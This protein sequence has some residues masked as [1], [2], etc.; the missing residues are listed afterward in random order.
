MLEQEREMSCHYVLK[1]YEDFAND[2]SQTEQK[3]AFNVASKK[4]I[5]YGCINFKLFNFLNKLDQYVDK[6]EEEKLLKNIQKKYS[7][8]G[9]VVLGAG[10]NGILQNLINIFVTEK[11][12]NIVTPF[13]TFMQAS[14]A[15]N[16]KQAQTR[17]AKMNKN[18]SINFENILKSVDKQTKMIFLCNPNNPTNLYENVNDIVL[19]AQKVQCPIVVSEASIAFSQDRTLLD[20]K[21][22]P[23]NIIVLRSFS[24]EFGLSGLRL[25]FAVMSDNYYQM[26]KAKTPTHV[27]S[28]ISIKIANMVFWSRT[29]EKNIKT[30]I[31]ERSYLTSEF[32]KIGL[33]V[34][35]SKSNA[36]MLTTQF[37]SNFLKRLREK[38]ISFVN[39]KGENGGWFIRFAVKTH[40]ENK[41]LIKILKE[42]Q[43]ENF[44]GD[45]F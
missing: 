11:S 15:L 2:Y 35:I 44:F 28:L 43:N 14:Y 36:I 39:I 25:G 22:L 9:K 16:V 23:K 19:L 29:I 1:E 20:L 41:R 34:L 17:F 7:I 31:K 6:K 5:K 38:N 45:K 10:A 37:D 3:F 4:L 42:V 12:D 32:E 8:H 26:Y 40:K 24:K 33:N 18:F 21:N 30:V 13:Y 27:V